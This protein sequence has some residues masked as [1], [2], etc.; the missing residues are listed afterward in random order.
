MDNLVDLVSTLGTLT[1]VNHAFK[2]HTGNFYT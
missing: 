2:D 1:V